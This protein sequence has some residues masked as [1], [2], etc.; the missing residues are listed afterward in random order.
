MLSRYGYFLRPFL[1][2]DRQ[3][4]FTARF[5]NA[6]FRRI[7][8]VRNGAG[9]WRHP[10]AAYRNARQ[11]I[12]KTE[13]V[14]HR[15]R[16]SLPT[17]VELA[18]PRGGERRASRRPAAGSASRRAGRTSSIV[19]LDP[20]IS[21]RLRP[22]SDSLH[23]CTRRQGEFAVYLTPAADGGHAPPATALG[24]GEV[25]NTGIAAGAGAGPA[26]GGR[27]RRGAVP[28]GRLAGTRHAGGQPGRCAGHAPSAKPRSGAPR[29][30]PVRGPRTRGE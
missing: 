7:N 6:A 8:Q 12:D 16:Q 21:R 5:K 1:T 20:V 23:R 30:R 11:T 22:V 27:D 10:G 25:R 9:D 3:P 15:P 4:F 29:P 24:A 26:D 17:D 19:P 28:V 13:S 2:A 18:T 14:R